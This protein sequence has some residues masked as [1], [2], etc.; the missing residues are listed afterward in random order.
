MDISNMKNIV[1]LK[2]LPS[3][4]VEEAIVVIKANKKIKKYQ[5]K[6][7]QTQKNVNNN[8]KKSSEV[9]DNSQYIVKEAENVITHYISN[10]EMKSPK[11]KNN[12]KKLEKRY[13]K[14]LKLNFILGFISLVSILLS[15]I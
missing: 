11:W 13:K 12:L 1:V 2:D 6:E 9:V 4:L 10:L 3:N 14:S 15:V 5:Y 8:K 7:S